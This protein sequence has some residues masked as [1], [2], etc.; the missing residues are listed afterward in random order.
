MALTI[1][2]DDAIFRQQT[3]GGI[4]RIWQQLIPALITEM[5]DAQIN[6]GD[7]ADVFLSTYYE[8]PQNDT[9]SVVMVYDF[10]S[11]RY[12]YVGAHHIDAM[13]KR[14]AI[15]RADAIIAISKWTAQDC[16]SYCDREA[17][18][19]Y[20]GQSPIQRTS[21]SAVLQFREH[22]RIDFPYFLV[23]GRRGLYKNVRALYQA[24]RIWPSAPN[25]GIVCIGIEPPTVDEKVFAQKYRWMQFTASDDE[26]A[27]AYTDAIALVY[28]GLYEGF[29]LP[30][31]EAMQC[32]CPVIC[33]IGGALTEVS[34]GAAVMVDG[35]KPL[36]IAAALD[37]MQ[38]PQ[39]RLE[40][41]L[42]G[43]EQAKEFSW[44]K[45]AIQVANVIRS[46]V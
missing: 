25:Y 37:Y 34:D 5:P 28:S 46:I 16:L 42:K 33:G 43:Y 32:G 39:K 13:K 12:P 30:V 22:Y 21:L 23:V 14:E 18:V 11:E 31:L 40:T 19:I 44:Q 7:H 36:E 26:L 24:W 41:A 17:T 29:G 27:A 2:I 20:P 15:R 4:S 35:C 8:L 1:H 6:Q 3:Q 38:S 45:A 10:L 9:K